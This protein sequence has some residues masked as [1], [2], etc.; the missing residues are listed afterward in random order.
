MLLLIDHVCTDD[1]I[2][3]LWQAPAGLTPDV[4][5]H[6][7]MCK[8]CDGCTITSSSDKSATVRSQ[9]EVFPVEIGT[10]SYTLTPHWSHPDLAAAH[11]ASQNSQGHHASTLEMESD[12]SSTCL[13]IQAVLVGVEGQILSRA[14]CDVGQVRESDLSPC[15]R[16]ADPHDTCSEQA[17]PS[18]GE[19]TSLSVSVLQHPVDA[20]AAEWFCWKALAAQQKLASGVYQLRRYKPELMN[21]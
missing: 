9:Y 17:F 5:R 7:H 4:W 3:R 1:D 8:L 20:R 14:R 19:G 16:Q 15:H 2:R 13:C 21:A 10:Q 12:Q 18:S 11:V 6:L